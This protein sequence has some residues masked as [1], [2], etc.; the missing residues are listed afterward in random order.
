MWSSVDGYK[1]VCENELVYL[2]C[3]AHNSRSLIWSSREYIGDSTAIEFNRLFDRLGKGKFISLPNGRATLSQLTK[4]ENTSLLSDLKIQIPNNFSSTEVACMNS[5]G[6]TET[7]T[8][9]LAEGTAICIHP[10][11]L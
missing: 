6:E 2:T 4:I 9:I 5:H 11:I 10:N 1:T 3:W 7:K 8:F